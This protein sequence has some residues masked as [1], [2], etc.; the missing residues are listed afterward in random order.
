MRKASQNLSVLVVLLLTVTIHLCFSCPTSADPSGIEGVVLDELGAVIPDS[1]V[2]LISPESVRQTLTDQAGKFMFGDLPAG[3]YELQVLHLGFKPEIVN[4]L[5][6]PANYTHPISI[7][8]HLAATGC[9]ASMQFV[10]AS[11]NPRSGKEN[12][13]GL[14]HDLFDGP[15]RG[16]TVTL[17]SQDAKRTYDKKAGPDGEFHF[18]GVVPGKYYLEVTAAGY[19]ESD[20]LPIWIVR[21]NVTRLTPIYIQ[22]KRES[23]VIICR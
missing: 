20:K 17:I 15:L 16:A 22:K 7:T 13:T 19:S 11:Y 2:R 10:S 3:N 9:P 4:K 1:S 5:I 14:V 21:D 18:E 6:V 23:R 12:L 8:L